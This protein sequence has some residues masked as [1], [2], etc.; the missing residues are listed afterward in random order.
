MEEK[1]LLSFLEKNARMEVKDL[2]DILQES[3]ENIHTS[4]IDGQM[5]IMD[6]FEEAEG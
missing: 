1:V 3:E 2:S 6:W 5:T 4:E